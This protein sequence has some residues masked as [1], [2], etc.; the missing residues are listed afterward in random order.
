M[1]SDTHNGVTY[2]VSRARLCRQDVLVMKRERHRLVRELCD[3]PLQKLIGLSLRLD[4][5]RQLMYGKEPRA[6]DD[7]LAQLQL[8]L[9]KTMTDVRE[10]MVELRC[11]RLTSL[12]LSDVVSRYTRLR[13]PNR[14]SGRRGSDRSSQ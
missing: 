1:H 12:S 2:A 5:C 9:H 11:P 14:P 4:P 3:G 13:G 7:E 6:L 8:D 10:L